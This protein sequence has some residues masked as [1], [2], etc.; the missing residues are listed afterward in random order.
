MTSVALTVCV[1]TAAVAWV[2]EVQ[3]VGLGLV[4]SV[5]QVP[6]AEKTACAEK[7]AYVVQVERV[8]VVCSAS[9][10]Y[11]DVV[12][13]QQKCICLNGFHS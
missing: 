4:V 2:A 5:G 11:F 12:P 3:F 13:R 8:E 9:A 10:S 1:V 6:C 7:I